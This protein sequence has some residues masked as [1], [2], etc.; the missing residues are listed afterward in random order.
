MVRFQKWDQHFQTFTSAGIDITANRL[1]GPQPKTSTY[2]CI[3]ELRIGHVK[4]LL[5]TL[6]ARLMAAAGNA[7][8]LNFADLANAPAG[9][10]LPPLGPDG[11][12]MDLLSNQIPQAFNSNICEDDCQLCRS[13]LVS[14]PGCIGYLI[15]SWGDAWY[16]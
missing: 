5:T 6:D 8:R 11:G 4:L 2:V 3:W 10:Y 13:D 14:R 16:Q 9:T 7:F 1:F 15:T 12:F